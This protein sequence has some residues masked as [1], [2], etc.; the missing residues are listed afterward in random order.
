MLLEKENI[1]SSEIE[2]SGPCLTCK[3]ASG[4]YKRINSLVPILFCEDYDLY[5]NPDLQV[6]SVSLHKNSVPDDKQN[7]R[8]YTGLCIDCDQREFCKYH[9]PEGGVWHCEEYE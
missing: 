9:K 5:P 4:C 8:T 6:N 2:Y 7:A 3:Y 1:K